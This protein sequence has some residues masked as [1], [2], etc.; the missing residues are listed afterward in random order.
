MP[1][2]SLRLVS[3]STTKRPATKLPISELDGI[4]SRSPGMI[5]IYQYQTGQYVYVNRAITHLLGYTPEEMLDGGLT[6]FTEKIHPDDF[7]G[8]KIRNEL[9]SKAVERTGPE[10]NDKV[11]F[12]SFEYRVKAKDGRYVWLHTDASVYSR[13]ANGE[14]EYVVNTCVDITEQKLFE[15][16]LRQIAKQLQSS[17]NALRVEH[18]QLLALNVAKDEFVS[19]ASHQL[20]MP[21]TGVKQYIGLLLQGYAGEL[22]DAQL[23]ILRA[24]YD[25]NERQLD[26]ISNLLSTSRLD[27]GKVQPH[28]K[29]CDLVSLTQQVVAEL[30]EKFQDRKQLV[31]FTYKAS[32]INVFVDERLILMVVE[33]ILDNAS[34]YSPDGKDIEITLVKKTAD[35]V[36]GVRDHGYGI[37]KVDQMKLF[38]KFSR[39]ENPLTENIAGT[40]LGLYWAKKVVDL[41]DG[42]IKLKSSTKSG[43]TFTVTLPLASE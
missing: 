17:Q 43:T 15:E 38:K 33:N 7:E 19:I 14:L 21:A 12:A 25:S 2:D 3:F 18:D 5:D 11:P 34:K 40:G 1:K 26:I 22:S 42:D 24:A 36:L 30:Q 39:I 20:R 23:T 32:P 9:A 10:V 29:V 8:S 31:T 28:K 41:H 13:S 6:F 27:A 35:A 37:P 16:K 4:A